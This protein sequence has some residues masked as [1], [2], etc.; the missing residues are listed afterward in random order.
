MMSARLRSSTWPGRRILPATPDPVA[1]HLTA[2]P[3]KMRLQVGAHGLQ[4]RRHAL[5]KALDYLFYLALVHS[6]TLPDLFEA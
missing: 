1:A 6:I 5:Q 4:G 3:E 2:A